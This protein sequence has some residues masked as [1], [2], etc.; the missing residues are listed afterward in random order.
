MPVWPFLLR[1]LWFPAP[2]V[3]SVL[4]TYHGEPVKVPLSLNRRPAGLGLFFN[5]SRFLKPRF[6][7]CEVFFFQICEIC[8]IFD[9]F[10]PTKIPIF[11]SK[12]IMVVDYARL[13]K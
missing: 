10:F 9:I 8:Q 11:Q 2:D 4:E 12:K 7:I 6:L 5:P 3:T 1:Y 13:G